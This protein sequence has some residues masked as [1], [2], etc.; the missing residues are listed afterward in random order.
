MALTSWSTT[1]RHHPD[2][3]ADDLRATLDRYLNDADRDDADIQVCAIPMPEHIFNVLEQ[4]ASIDQL[5]VIGTSSPDLTSELLSRRAAK[6]LRKSNCSVIIAH[7]DVSEYHEQLVRVMTRE[8][9]CRVLP[10]ITRFW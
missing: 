1:V 7:G 6:I 4:S 2:P 8:S 9:K 5:V 10:M 3:E